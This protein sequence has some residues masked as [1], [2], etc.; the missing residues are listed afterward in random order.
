MVKPKLVIANLVIRV[1][2]LK[3]N[4]QGVGT[5]AGMPSA[6]FNQSVV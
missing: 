5:C 1:I 4:L 6:T 3:L 2:K